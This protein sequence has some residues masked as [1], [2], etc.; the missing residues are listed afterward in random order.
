MAHG[1]FPRAYISNP[2]IDKPIGEIYKDLDSFTWELLEEDEDIHDNVDFTVVLPPLCYEG[3]F[4]KGLFFSRGV[5]YLHNSL[6][7]LSNLFF[8]MAYSMFCSYP[9]AVSADA[10]LV[11]YLNPA[12]EAWFRRERPAQ[13]QVHV[14]PLAETDHM[15]EYRIAPVPGLGKNIDVLSVSRLQ[16]V[17][18]VAMIAHAL[19]VYRSKYT[20]Q[21]RMTLITGNRGGVS[22]DRL[23]PYAC[24]QLA[25]IDRILGRVE[26]YID[27]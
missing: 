8:S 19:K 1:V 23:P 13:A 7:E 5:D 16:D 2:N 27:L 4:V 26:D 17:K 14:I 21:I 15:D 12:R 6:P 18:N 20:R 3:H 24:K 9:W 10:H 11:C 25:A 22:P